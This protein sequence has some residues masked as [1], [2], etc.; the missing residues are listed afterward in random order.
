VTALIEK[1]LHQEVMLN[2]RLLPVV[3]FSVPNS[4]YLP[5]RSEAERTMAK[6]IINQMKG[7]GQLTP[8]APDLVLMGAKGALCLEL[9]RPAS[10]DLFTT[11]PRGRLSPEQKAFRAQCERAGVRYLV[12]YEWADVECSLGGLF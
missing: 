11:R 5:A 9:K 3:A 2:L 8:G 12:A 7:A 6:R 1:T 4:V 10:R